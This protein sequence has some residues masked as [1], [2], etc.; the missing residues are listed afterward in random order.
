MNQCLGDKNL[1]STGALLQSSLKGFLLNIMTAP[2][3]TDGPK[4]SIS[5]QVWCY[6]ALLAL[7]KVFQ[8]EGI[9]LQLSWRLQYLAALPQIIFSGATRD[10]LTKTL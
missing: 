1:P 10:K 4:S 9:S 7:G 6:S 5:L 2:S 3:P 8:V